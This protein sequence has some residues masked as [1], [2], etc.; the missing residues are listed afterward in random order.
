MLEIRYV[1]ITEEKLLEGFDIT[2]NHD[3]DFAFTVIIA[4][5]GTYYTIQY[6][7]WKT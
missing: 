4:I 7:Y 6:T 2:G 5:I 3:I 1:H